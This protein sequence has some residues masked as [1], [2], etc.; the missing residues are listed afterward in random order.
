MSLIPL[1]AR[2]FL[3]AAKLR[4]RRSDRIGRA[5][6]VRARPAAAR[7]PGSGG[8]PGAR[9]GGHGLTSADADTYVI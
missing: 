2:L 3:N 4:R 5:T 7:A 9:A 6:A 1:D 8:E